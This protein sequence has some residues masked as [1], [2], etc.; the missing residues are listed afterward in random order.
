MIVG[1]GHVKEVGKDTAAAA[2]VRDLGFRR[3]SFAD[4][5]KKLALAIDP[6]IVPEPETVNVRVGQAHLAWLVRQSGWEH[7]KKNYKE[8]RRFLQ[9]LGNEMREMFGNDIWIRRVAWRAGEREDLL[10]EGDVVIPDVRYLNEAEWIKSVGGLLIKI[11]RPGKVAEG[12]VSETQLADFP[13]DF[14]IENDGDVVQLEQTIVDRVRAF[15][16]KPEATNPP[17]VA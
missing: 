11:N 5:L 6:L 16:F 4:D 3:D 14:E 13:W 12:H 17:L 8:A 2:L 15:S 1:I 9:N 10:P 7:V